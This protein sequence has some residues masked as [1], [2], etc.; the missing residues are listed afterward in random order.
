MSGA[1][2]ADDERPDSDDGVEPDEESDFEFEEMPCTDESHWDAFIP[3]EDECDPLPEEGD[4][5]G[6]ADC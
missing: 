2:P 5:W 3:D 1:W 6:I 4:F